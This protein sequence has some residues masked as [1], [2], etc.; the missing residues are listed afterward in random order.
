LRENRT[1]PGQGEPIGSR[2]VHYLMRLGISAVSGIT[3]TPASAGLSRSTLE[4]GGKADI[5]EGPS[6]ARS[7]PSAGVKDGTISLGRNIGLLDRQADDVAARSRQNSRPGRCRPGP[8]RLD[9]VIWRYLADP[10]DAAEDLAAGEDRWELP[11]LD[12]RRAH[13]L[14]SC[15]SIQFGR[16][17]EIVP[18]IDAAKASGTASVNVLA[19][20]RE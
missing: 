14:S 7:R 10:W 20:L 2:P 13:T 8:P 3:A 17:E 11:P 5:A 1:L 12:M 19:I 16:P 4:R 15:R 9:K 18:A 6:R